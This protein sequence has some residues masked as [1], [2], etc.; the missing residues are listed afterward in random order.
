MITLFWFLVLA[1]LVVF[2]VD[3]DHKRRN[4]QR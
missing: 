4:D 3:I 1:M 2:G